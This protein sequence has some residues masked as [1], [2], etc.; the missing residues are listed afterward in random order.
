MILIWI[1]FSLPQS[2][3]LK[4]YASIQPSQS[5]NRIHTLHQSKSLLIDLFLTSD[6]QN[7]LVSGVGVPFFEQNIRYHCPIY[8]VL[9]FDKMISPEFSRHV[10]L[11][12]KG[13][14][15]SLSDEIYILLTGNP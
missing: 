11:Y 14:Y 12:D 1:C 2:V 13:N 7:I 6:T 10:W 5:N 3:N 8:Y 4:P 15:R 9:S